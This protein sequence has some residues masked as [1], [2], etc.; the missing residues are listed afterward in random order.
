MGMNLLYFFNLNIFPFALIVMLFPLYFSRKVKQ[1]LSLFSK[2]FAFKV[3][4]S[5]KTH[6]V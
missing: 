1:K 5:D 4:Y 6:F 3:V 2:C